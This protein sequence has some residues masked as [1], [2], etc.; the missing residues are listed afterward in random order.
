M[1]EV[2]LT[3][4]TWQ[5]CIRCKRRTPSQTQKQVVK[6]ASSVPRFSVSPLPSKMIVFRVR[7]GTKE[8]EKVFLKTKYSLVE[9]I[10]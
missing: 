2:R 3:F 8:E 7:L 5:V 10:L 1:Y 6:L 9:K 4:A